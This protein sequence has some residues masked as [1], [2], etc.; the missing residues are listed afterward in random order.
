MSKHYLC[1]Q[2][3]SVC[4]LILALIYTLVFLTQDMNIQIVVLQ[5]LYWSL[6]RTS[7]NVR[8]ISY[9]LIALAN[10]LLAF[11]FHQ[12]LKSKMSTRWIEYVLLFSISGVIL[13]LL[14]QY[15]YVC[16]DSPVIFYFGFPLSWLR[17]VTNS[18]NFLPAAPI[19][20][21][22]QNYSDFKW[23]I[24][25]WNLFVSFS[26]WFNIGFILFAI[27]NLQWGSDSI[28]KCVK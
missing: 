14:I 27:R 26:F 6:D 17:G 16:C 2:V 13:G 15:A 22:I 9:L 7:G 28:K 19:S 18:W 8:L 25:L 10:T 11:G 21:L 24:T 3:L 4:S 12:Q 23:N 20:Y 5:G 1:F